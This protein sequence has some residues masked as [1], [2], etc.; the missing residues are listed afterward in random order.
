M[1]F[2]HGYTDLGPSSNR[3]F[4]NLYCVSIHHKY[5]TTDSILVLTKFLDGAFKVFIVWK[6]QGDGN[7]L[8]V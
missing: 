2:S 1:P 7:N 4:C 8:K 5:L 6:L 3:K